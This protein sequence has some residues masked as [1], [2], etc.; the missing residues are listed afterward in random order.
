M[1]CYVCGAQVTPGGTACPHCGSYVGAAATLPTKEPPRTFRYI[2]AAASALWVLGLAFAVYFIKRGDLSN[3]WPGD[4]SIGR[5]VL[6]GD[7]ARPRELEAR[8]K[9][10]FVPMGRQAFSVDSLA[11]YY[12]N[13]FQ[14]EITVLPEVP[15]GVQSFIAPRQQYVAEEMILDMK[16]AYPK[17]AR[18]PDS[19]IIILTDEDIFPRSLGW[20][21][22]YSFHTAYKYAV[23]SSRRNDPAFWDSSQPHNP[24]A[25]LAS[26]KQMLTKYI[27]LLY[28]HL[29]HS[30]DPT[31]IMYQ[32]LE[33]RPKSDE[34]YE[35]DLHSEQSANGARFRGDWAC[36]IHT[37]SYKSG[38]IK[39]FSPFVEECGRIPRPASPDQEVLVTGVVTGGFI[40]YAMDF[41][42]DSSPPIDFVRAYHSLS[43]EHKVLGR[44]MTHSYNAWLYAKD[45]LKLS[46]LQIVQETET[47]NLTLNRLVP[48]S[49]FSPG[50]EFD[51]PG[52]SSDESYGARMLLDSAMLKLR[53][54]DGASY[55]FPACVNGPCFWT[56]YQDADGHSLVFDRDKAGDLHGLHSSD[57]QGIE[58]QMAT[59]GL[60]ANRMGG[61]TATDGSKVFYE[62]DVPARLVAV[63][64]SDRPTTLYEYDVNHRMTKMSVVQHEGDPPLLIVA[65]EYDST[66]RLSRQTF[67][68]GRV[69]RL[70]YKIGRDKSVIETKLTEPDGS[71]LTVSRSS[72]G[73]YVGRSLP[74]KFPA[75]AWPRTT[76]P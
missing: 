73:E 34:L 28:F 67:G 14:I 38:E 63:K 52:S 33:P 8:G 41:Q 56:G 32:P 74:V 61:G 27:A 68:D 47:G 12:R 66:G 76:R 62:Y 1:N 54:R 55:T 31:S 42:L 58:F 21:F 24:V 65:N 35:S 36:V 57:G 75:V 30:F 51:E 39:H 7:I 11:D 17:I 59:K 9:L 16:R 29:P 6:H 13:K 10:Y 3:L 64:R 45:P 5:P 70:E 60:M 43:P 23:V 18:A 40:E 37:Y 26:L 50:I 19:V 2:L 15:M 46:S 69:L 49:G 71:V 44:G 22:T 48:G 72:D 20:K 25:Q 53:Y 4:R